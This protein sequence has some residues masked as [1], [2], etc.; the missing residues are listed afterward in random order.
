[1]YEILVG[2]SP[3]GG[4]SV[5]EVFDNVVQFKIVWPGIGY[6]EDMITP[7]AQD[8]ILKFLEKDPSKRL[9]SFEKI[10]AHPYFRGFDWNNLEKHK[11]QIE[12]QRQNL[13]TLMKQSLLYKDIMSK[14]TNK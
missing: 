7:E 9:R 8:L 12:L 6:E 5:K 13:S 11:P 3:F 10:K 4:M 14:N 1:M 2:V